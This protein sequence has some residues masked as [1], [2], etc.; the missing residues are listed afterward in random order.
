MTEGDSTDSPARLPVPEAA[1]A[2]PWAL[3]LL[4]AGAVVSV[5]LRRRRAKA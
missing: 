2:T 4:A 1:A 5:V 3:V